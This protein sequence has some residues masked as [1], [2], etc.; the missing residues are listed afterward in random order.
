MQLVL[1]VH[2]RFVGVVRGHAVDRG[3]NVPHTPSSCEVH[4]QPLIVSS[5]LRYRP[6]HLLGGAEG[7]ILTFVTHT[8][9]PLLMDAL[10]ELTKSAW[11]SLSSS[12]GV[13]RATL[14]GESPSVSAD[15]RSG[16]TA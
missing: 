14:A 8:S 10:Q 13:S 7:K 9:K 1:D 11:L 12:V 5:V 15:M 3:H 6:P 16:M 4:Q 2:G